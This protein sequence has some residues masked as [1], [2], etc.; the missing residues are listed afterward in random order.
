M[1]RK[2]SVATN[3]CRFDCQLLWPLL[4]PLQ[5]ILLSN[6]SRTL[7]MPLLTDTNIALVLQVSNAALL[8]LVS[9]FQTPVLNVLL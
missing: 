8:L 1:N 9:Q 6:P 7:V 3:L 4:F 2:Q 5:S